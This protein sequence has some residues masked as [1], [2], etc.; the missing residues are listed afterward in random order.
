[1][2]HPDHETRVGAH[3]IFSIVLMPSLL[4]PCSVQKKKTSEAVSCDLSISASKKVRSQSFAF[5]DEGK[6]QV[7]LIDERLKENENQASDMTVK[8]SIMCQSHGH[9]YSFKHALDDGKMV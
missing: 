8:E 7:E 1:M 4:S 5:Q 6:D 3:S 9:S 2:A